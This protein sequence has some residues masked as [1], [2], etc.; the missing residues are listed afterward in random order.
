MHDKP[1]VWKVGS[2][3]S[4]FG[5]R[6]TSI[7]DIFRRNNY[8]F[9]GSNGERF[10]DSVERND[11]QAIAD[12]Y[13]IV[14]VAKV[15]D[16]KPSDL[17]HLMK[18]RKLRFRSSDSD[19]FD[20]SNPDVYKD[21]C[22]GVRVHWVDL[23]AHERFKYQKAGTFYGANMYWDRI[24]DLYSHYSNQVFDI[25]S[26]TLRLHRTGHVSDPDGY[27]KADLLDGITVYSIPIYQREYSWSESQIV[28]FI[29]DIFASYWGTNPEE[30][31]I[32]KDPMFIGTMQ[33]SQKRFISKRESGQDIIDGQQRISTLLCLLKYLCLRFPDIK[34]LL[35]PGI[36]SFDWL[37]TRVN[38]D[39]EDA[40]LRKLCGLH[41]ISL[42]SVDSENVYVRNCAIIGDV[43]TQSITDDQ[44]KVCE[45]FN[46]EDFCDHLLNNIYFVVVETVAGLSKTVQIF[47][48]INTAGLDLN[49]DDIFKVRF[50]EYLHD[51]CGEGDEAFNEIGNV[52][53]RIKLLNDDWRRK[54]ND[55]DLLNMSTV[56]DVYKDYL[57]SRFDL[58]DSLYQMATDTF[59]E[60]LF[61]VIL[62]VQE[63]KDFGSKTK[64]VSL[65]IAD[66]DL[67]VDKI[68]K[69]NGSDFSNETELI[70]YKLIEKS[71]YSRYT[72]ICYLLL[73]AGY[74]IKQVYEFIDPLSRV[75]FCYSVAY[76]KTIYS[77]HY[78]S[79]KVLK[80]IGKSENATTLLDYIRQKLHNAKEEM[81]CFRKALDRPVWR[82]MVCCVSAYLDEVEKGFTDLK[83]LNHKLSF[84]YDI[85]HIH[86]NA[87]S[88]VDVDDINLQNS[89]GN[90]VL[91][92]SFINRSIQDLPF[93][94]KVD[95][96]DGNCCYKDSKYA[97]ISK[98]RKYSKWEK[99]E[100][101]TRLDSE[102]QRIVDFVWKQ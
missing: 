48:T 14:A 73:V 40:L 23:P 101:T 85:E 59:F 9:V 80:L 3:W 31:I 102:F 17:C 81:H 82:D 74:D 39:V 70:S 29:H 93:R 5:A 84:G 57:I 26:R 43:F 68:A 25:T 7:V 64:G 16:E 37:E 56:R 99:E 66:L 61:D 91:L 86:A 18:D 94:E 50:Y 44:G 24:I 100:I 92:E 8:V 1:R 38:N 69:W 72:R 11:Y 12:G 42:L 77:I 19:R 32:S 65:S 71:R 13:T 45:Q 96:S 78:F 10:R 36:S 15:L 27:K 22:F 53:E 30:H 55:W 47:N 4:E 76:A 28:R 52:Y 33:V 95:R 54:G 35:P 20:Y 49:G 34:D 97:S 67:I 79:Y 87:D 60:R 51:K 75:Y 63:H 98:I 21:W 62:D 90:L 41:D 46:I 83:E 58:S 2:R 89:I 88:S 6:G